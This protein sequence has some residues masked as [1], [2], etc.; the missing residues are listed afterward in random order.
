M[1]PKTILITGSSEGG[2]GDA[3]AK[4]FHRRGHRVFATARNLAKVQHLKKLGLEILLLDVTDDSSIKHAVESV[5]IAT[6]GTLDILV[7]NSGAGY[8]QPLLDSDISVAKKMYDLNVFALIAV[9][10]AF[11]PLLMASKGTIVNIGSIAGVAP[12]P[13]QG[14]YNASKAAVNLITDQLRLELSP[15]GIK[16]ILVVTGVISTHFF[17]NIEK[18]HVS[19]NSLYYPA[20]EL[21]EPILSGEFAKETMGGGMNVDV[22]AKAVVA[23][24]LKNNPKKHHWIGESSWSI[25]FASTF[26]WSTIWDTAFA[27]LMKAN[28]V[29]QKILAAKKSD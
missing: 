2:I 19:E 7:N 16:V 1:T 21:I 27:G 3:L 28:E 6:G 9:T 29:K 13:W 24:V 8:N 14:F 11:A 23:N 10:Q 20:K 5:K 18:Q 4:E 17:N 12:I 22:Y 26:G 25:W 15:W